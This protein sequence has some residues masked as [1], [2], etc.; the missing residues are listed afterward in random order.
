[1][2]NNRRCTR[3]FL[4]VPKPSSVCMCMCIFVYSPVLGW[5]ACMR[6]QLWLVHVSGSVNIVMDEAGTEVPSESLRAHKNP[7]RSRTRAVGPPARSWRKESAC[8][9]YQRRSQKSKFIDIV[10][11]ADLQMMDGKCVTVFYDQN[12][13]SSTKT[14]CVLPSSPQALSRAMNCLC[15]AVQTGGHCPVSKPPKSVGWRFSWRRMHFGSS[16]TNWAQKWLLQKLEG[17]L[18][19]TFSYSRIPHYL[20][21]QFIPPPFLW[22]VRRHYVHLHVHALQ[23]DVSSVPG[24]D[25]WNVSCCWIRS[26]YGLCPGW[27]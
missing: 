13:L 26:A 15:T 7:A 2:W 4:N 17:G 24:A 3:G 6:V 25:L 22:D 5:H 16:L 10:S 27:W 8:W 11:L 19:M 14:V 21:L 1:M 9:E 18:S 23:E 12:C 20:S